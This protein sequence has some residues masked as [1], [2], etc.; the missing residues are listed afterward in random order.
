MPNEGAI[1]ADLNS[2]F[3]RYM[4][5]YLRITFDCFQLETQIL[6]ATPVTIYDGSFLRPVEGPGETR[7]KKPDFGVCKENGQGASSI[8]CLYMSF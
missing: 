1:Q 6:L 7:P 2:N 3:F 5:E 4:R 8:L